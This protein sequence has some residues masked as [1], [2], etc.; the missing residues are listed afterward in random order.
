LWRDANERAHNA[1]DKVLTGEGEN[2]SVENGKVVLDL[3]PQLG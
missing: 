3:T 1:V 2:V